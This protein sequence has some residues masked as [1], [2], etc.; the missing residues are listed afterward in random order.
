M[1]EQ[2]TFKEL[3][4]D[5]LQ[6]ALTLVRK[7]FLEYEAPDYSDEGIQEFMRFVE[8]DAMKRMLTESKIHIWTCEDNNKIV[9]TLGARPDHINLLFVDGRYHRKGIAKQLIRIMI[10]HFSPS[11]VTVNSSPYAVEVYRKLGFVNTDTEQTV[12]G[13]RYIPMKRKI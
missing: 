8:D 4:M 12:N 1:K 11:A 6:E 5:R 2:F 3:E 9:G 10:E 7:V 13:L